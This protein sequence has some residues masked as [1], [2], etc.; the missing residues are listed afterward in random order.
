MEGFELPIRPSLTESVTDALTTVARE[1]ILPTHYLQRDD[2][3]NPIETPAEMFQRVARNVAVAEAVAEGELTLS[4]T[5]RELSLNAVGSN[6]LVQELFGSESPPDSRR[7]V[8]VDETTV[9]A[10]P[11]DTLYPKLHVGAAERVDE[12]EA[13]FLDAMTSLGFVP[14]SPALS[15]AGTATQQL[16]SCFV[17]APKGTVPSV[18]ETAS[19]AARVLKSGGGVGYALGDLPTFLDGDSNGRIPSFPLRVL[20]LLDRLPNSVLQSGRR[21]G[22]Q[23]GVLPV[24]HPAAVEFIH[25][26]MPEWS[27]QWQLNSLGSSLGNAVPSAL[28]AEDPPDHLRS[29]TTAFLSNFNLSIGLTD[30]FMSALAAGESLALRK[31]GSDEPVRTT[32]RL[33]E[34]YERYDLGDYVAV[35][36]PLRLPAAELWERLVA[37]AHKSGEPGVVFVD[38][39]QQD[40]SIPG[41]TEPWELVRATDPCG[42]QPLTEYESCP[43]GHVNLSTVVA[44]NAPTWSGG[45]DETATAAVADFLSDALD[46]ERLNHLV[47]TG[48]RFLDDAVTM[49]VHPLAE[50]ARRVGRLRKVGLGVMGL[51]HL[52]VQLGVKYGTPVGNEIARQ[53]VAHVNRRSTQASHRL[54]MEMGA[55]PLWSESKYAEPTAH[56]EWFRRHTGCDPDEWTEGYRVRN[57]KTTGVAPCGTTS[58]VG[59]T[60]GGC[61][62]IYEAFYRRSMR[63]GDNH[64]AEMIDEYVRYALEANGISPRRVLAE[65]NEHAGVGLGDLPSVPNRLAE[66]VVTAHE[67]TPVE[68]VD[69]Q[70]A[71]QRG[72][73]AAVSKT[74]NLSADST[75]ADVEKVIWRAYRNRAK[76]ITVYR[77]SGRSNQVL[78]PESDGA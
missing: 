19:D 26:K 74:C 16:A 44:D 59:G 21:R 52:F 40:H 22:A 72:V 64:V 71:C 49:S 6:R 29:V 47:D 76:G 48:I 37:A 5:P 55:F 41:G 1:R 75:Q 35:G 42:V 14:N 68:H 2:E 66:L 34:L 78:T 56:P 58:I 28:A 17:L 3:G 33:A 18:M 7:E 25:A 8:V 36:E 77:D 50:T 27:A 32:P 13:A 53:V 61:E 70:C 63:T 73:D 10:F 9:A 46:W 11:Y 38:R 54:A 23:I 30:R 69:A 4:V 24:H 12:A 20:G 31:P 65:A 57:H 51:A 62:P 45:T 43:L 60:S 67:L 39:L 15:N